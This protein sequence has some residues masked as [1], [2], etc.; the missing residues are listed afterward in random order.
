MGAFSGAIGFSQDI[1][2]IKKYFEKFFST[3]WTVEDG[4]R[5]LITI[6]TSGGYFGEERCAID[7]REILVS[8]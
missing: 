5:G 1:R 4:R 8:R 6:G 2:E 7:Q 3:V